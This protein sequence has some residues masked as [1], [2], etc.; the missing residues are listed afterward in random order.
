MIGFCGHILPLCLNAFVIL[1][2]FFIIQD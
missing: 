1:G 2:I